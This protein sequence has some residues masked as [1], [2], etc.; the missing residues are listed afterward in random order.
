MTAGKTC[1]TCAHFSALRQECRRNSPTAFLVMGAQGPAAVG[2]WPTTSADQ[3]CGEHKD[4]EQKV[5]Q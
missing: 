1:D 4:V 3:W 2:A 5:M